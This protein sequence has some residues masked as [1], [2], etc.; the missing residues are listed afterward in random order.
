MITIFN[1]DNT[2]ESRAALELESLF[3]KNGLF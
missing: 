2:S 1:E 3:L